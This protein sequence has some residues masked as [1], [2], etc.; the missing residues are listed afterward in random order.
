METLQHRNRLRA[1]LL[2]IAT[3]T[4]LGLST[5]MAKVASSAG[6]APGAYLAWSCLGAGL[7][8]LTIGAARNNLPGLRADIL[9]YALVA[10]ALSL[11]LPNLLFVSAI[12]HVGAS[13]VALCIAFPPLFTYLGAIFLRLERPDSWRLFGI[14]LALVGGA[15]VALLKLTVADAPAPWVAAALVGPVILAGGNLYRT[16][17]WPV[18]VGPDQLAPGMLLFASLLIILA[19][20]ALGMPLSVSRSEQAAVIAGQ[21][22]VY[23]GQFALLFRLQKAGGPVYLSLLGSTAA[24]TGIPFALLVLEEPLPDGILVGGALIA[25]GVGALTMRSARPPRPRGAAAQS[26]QP[27]E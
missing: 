18:G 3:G 11:A 25:V 16:I 17:G 21:A 8:L 26:P 2:L 1:L 24:I 14:M 4:L 19:S 20:L 9:R 5:N 12:P 13:F 23:A 15:Y 6:L 22:V 10:A 27:A 7:L